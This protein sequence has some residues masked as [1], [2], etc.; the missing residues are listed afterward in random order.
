[1][2]RSSRCE[3][4]Q[5]VSSDLSNF[6]LLFKKC[7]MLCS[8]LDYLFDYLFHCTASVLSKRNID[9][10]LLIGHAVFTSVRA[11]LDPHLRAVAK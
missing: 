2:V 7:S 3:I 5:R 4:P 1:M 6:V 9:H 11:R 8:H 10:S